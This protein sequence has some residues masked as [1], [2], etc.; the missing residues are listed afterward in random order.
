MSDS[1]VEFDVFGVSSSKFEMQASEKLIW[2][3]CTQENP[4]WISDSKQHFADPLYLI[5]N[6]RSVV[7]IPVYTKTQMWSVSK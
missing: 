5:L 7:S 4:G 2:F 6:Y 1:Q 3:I